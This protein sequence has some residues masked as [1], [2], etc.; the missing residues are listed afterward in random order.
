MLSVRPRFFS[1]YVTKLLS[2]D[3]VSGFLSGTLIL[4]LILLMFQAIRL[5]EFLVVHQASVKDIIVMFVNLM[6]SFLPISVPVAILFSVLTGISRANSEGEVLALQTSGFSPARIFFPLGIFTA[7]VAVVSVYLALYVVP[8]A[9]RRFELMIGQIDSERVMAALKPGVFLHG[10]YGLVLLAEHITPSRSEMKKVFIYDN[11]FSEQPL[12][13][14]AQEGVLQD[15]V[16]DGIR[17]LRLKDGAI[18][19]ERAASGR[20][21]QKINFRVY[22]INLELG[23]SSAIWRDYSAPSYTYPHLLKRMSECGGD[24]TTYRRLQIELHRRFSMALSVVVFAIVGFLI[25]CRSQKLGRSAVIVLGLFV[26]LLYWVTYLM[27]NALAVTGWVLPWLGIWA[28]NLV[29][30]ILGLLGFRRL[31]SP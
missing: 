13:I 27:A 15:F 18:Y 8:R 19:L 6:V 25:G 9:H 29:L 3:I 26:G 11:R 21:Q 20:A 1:W 14:T 5:S 12:S 24:V 2:L 28:P 16:Q 23:E 22:D 10:F 7:V 30:F 17:T 31:Y 4:S